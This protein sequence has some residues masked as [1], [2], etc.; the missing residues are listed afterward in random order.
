MHEKRGTLIGYSGQFRDQKS[1]DLHEKSLG[2]SN[3]EI[4]PHKILKSR[5]FIKSSILIDITTLH[6][7]TEGIH[8]Y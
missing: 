3:Y 5:T 2:L 1:L 4:F 7:N 6:Y 8:V